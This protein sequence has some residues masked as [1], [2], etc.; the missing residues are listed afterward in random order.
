MKGLLGPIP[1]GCYDLKAFA[2]DDARGRVV[3]AAVFAGTHTGDGGPV[4]P[5]G[6][7]VSSD[8]VYVIDFAGAKIRHM[9]K[10]W[11]DTH[12]LRDLGWA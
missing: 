11:N 5:T 12:A 2:L 9:T 6:R 7:R 4:P 10:V 8:Y 1:D 3:A